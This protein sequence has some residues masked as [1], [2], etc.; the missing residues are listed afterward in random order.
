MQVGNTI[1]TPPP[2]TLVSTPLPNSMALRVPYDN[3][4]PSV[5]N[6]QLDN[7]TN[8]NH[9]ALPKASHPQTNLTINSETE[10]FSIN[11][12]ARSQEL[13]VNP[14]TVFLAQL[15]AGDISP[16]V[17]TIFAQYDKLVSY[18]NVKY[19]PSNAGKPTEPIG[20]FGQFLQKE[21]LGDGLQ[22]PVQNYAQNQEPDSVEELPQ[23]EQLSTS[24]PQ[25]IQI[26]YHTIPESKLAKLNAYTDT[27]TRSTPETISSME[28]A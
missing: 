11:T 7:N 17:R 21:K 2:P 5:S 14:Q 20:I 10:N 16:E 6:T 1:N 26:T 24:T 3:V 8:G 22:Q 25:I 15:A 13:I 28:L 4:P 12:A 19:K 27:I 23:A 9:N 18:A